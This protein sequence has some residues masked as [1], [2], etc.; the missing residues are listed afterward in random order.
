MARQELPDEQVWVSLNQGTLVGLAHDNNAESAS[1]N[2]ANC[3]TVVF[4]T[5]TNRTYGNG[6]WHFYLSSKQLYAGYAWK[7]SNLNGVPEIG[8][9]QPPSVYDYNFTHKLSSWQCSECN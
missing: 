3:R 7:D 4:Y 8:H 1:S 9:A 2:A 5:S 6:R